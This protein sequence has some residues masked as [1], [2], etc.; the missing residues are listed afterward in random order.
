M[1][2]NTIKT[3]DGLTPRLR[4]KIEKTIKDTLIHG[5]AKFATQRTVSEK[6]NLTQKLTGTLLNTV[7]AQLVKDE[8]KRDSR[9]V[10]TFTSETTDGN[11]NYNTLIDY[12]ILHHYNG[13]TIRALLAENDVKVP[14]RIVYAHMKKI[15]GCYKTVVGDTKKGGRG[16]LDGCHLHGP[17]TMDTR[18]VPAYRRYGVPNFVGTHG[19]NIRMA[20]LAKRLQTDEPVVLKTFTRE[21]IRTK[22]LDYLVYKVISQGRKLNHVRTRLGL[23]HVLDEWGIP[24][25]PEVRSVFK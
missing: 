9:V 13:E 10:K 5:G 17:L 16:N 8:I 22:D 12:V 1:I 20:T 25:T 2:V 21:E 18:G 4:Q 15:K 3:E 11:T 23:Q 19:E 6:F 24:N 7:V 14:Y